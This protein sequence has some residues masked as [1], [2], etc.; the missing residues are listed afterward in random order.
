MKKTISLFLK[1]KQ[2]SVLCYVNLRILSWLLIVSAC[3]TLAQTTGITQRGKVT[4]VSTEFPDQYGKLLS[5]PTLSRFGVVPKVANMPTV[6]LGSSGNFVILSKSGITTTGVTSIIGNIGVS[7]IAATSMT[8]F[9]LVLDGSGQFSTSSLV[10][11]NVYAANYAN[12]SPANLNTAVADMEA[13]YL[14]AAGRIA[15]ISEL[16]TGEIGGLTLVAGVYK[17]STPISITTNV[18]LSGGQNDIWIFQTAGGLSLA[19]AVKVILIGGAKPKNIFWQVAGVA[20]LA[21]MSE[22]SGIV[23]SKTSVT[24]TS[25]AVLKGRALAQTNVTLIANTLTQPAP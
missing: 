13:A 4:D 9:G 17:W 21:T 25:G 5:T 3:P 1:H 14:D 20:S 7:P 23:L 12:P 11:G 16:G 24:M 19:S 2:R 10:S 6:V 18:T 22:L 15:G 8:G